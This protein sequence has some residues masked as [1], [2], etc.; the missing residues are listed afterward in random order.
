[1]GDEIDSLDHINSINTIAGANNPP[2]NREAL[3][4][5]S[6]RLFPNSSDNHAA[7]FGAVGRISQVVDP[8][9][10]P[11]A[12]QLP[13]PSSTQFGPETSMPD[14]TRSAFNNSNTLYPDSSMTQTS[15]TDMY[16][17]P[18]TNLT[19]TSSTASSLPFSS[20][21]PTTSFSDIA[22]QSGYS[23][24]A[25]SL[26]TNIML[27]TLNEYGPPIAVPHSGSVGSMSSNNQNYYQQRQ[28]PMQPMGPAYLQSSQ[29][30]PPRN[31]PL[32]NAE[33]IE[34]FI[35]STSQLQ[36]NSGGGNNHNNNVNS[37]SSRTSSSNN[38]N[39]NLSDGT[40]SQQSS[41][42]N[43]ARDNNPIY[44]PPHASSPPLDQIGH[45]SSSVT[46]T[47]PHNKIP[48]RVK[49]PPV[50]KFDEMDL[51]TLRK[52]YREYEIQANCNKRARDTIERSLNNMT[53]HSKGKNLELDPVFRQKKDDQRRCEAVGHEI[54][55]NMQ[56]IS[57][58]LF[59]KFGQKITNSSS[60]HHLDQ[61]RRAKMSTA[62]A[63]TSR[64]RNSRGSTSSGGAN[65]YS[66]LLLD[67]KDA[68]TW[69]QICDIH[70][71]SLKEYC[72]H[73]HK[74][75]HTAAS[76]KRPNPWRVSKD[77]IDLRKTYDIYKSICAK[78]EHEFGEN[79]FNMRKLD[80]ALNPTLKDKEKKLKDLAQNRERNK[81]EDSDPLLKIKGYDYL[82]PITGF[83]CSLCDQALC[84]FAQVEQHLKSYGHTYAHAKS[85]AIDKQ[86]EI[87]F[88]I[89]QDRSYKKTNVSTDDEETVESSKNS[90]QDTEVTSKHSSSTSSAVQYKKPTSHIVDDHEAIADKFP[91]KAA[92]GKPATAAHVP[93]STLTKSRKTANT[94]THDDDSMARKAQSRRRPSD[95]L[96]EIVPINDRSRTKPSAL[97]RLR[98]VEESGSRP[99]SRAEEANLV[100]TDSDSTPEPIQ[101]PIEEAHLASGDPDSPFPELY[102][103][104]T[105]NTH[106]SALRDKRLAQ[107]CRVVMNKINLDDYKDMLL[108]SATLYVRVNQL[109]AKK[110]PTK[111]AEELKKKAVTAPT[112]FDS[113]GNPIP[114]D[115]DEEVKE[116]KPKISRLLAKPDDT[117]KE[118]SESRRRNSDD[119][120]PSKSADSESGDKN[121]VTFDSEPDRDEVRF[122][123]TLLENFFCEK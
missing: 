85:V 54:R 73:L 38:N 19:S 92:V 67:L 120:Q 115:P 98:T 123:M 48:K 70:F 68:K 71:N 89:K 105:G 4:E 80:L 59:I 60:S 46:T 27:N 122:D 56:K 93:H 95:D 96:P 69:C 29:G 87:T 2:R 55:K 13:T 1:M 108:D 22:K 30:L 14:Q 119:L 114:V 42:I 53:R 51:L 24:G 33:Y 23:G 44:S 66:G 57:D 10:R 25:V 110:E 72:D 62:S 18:I 36:V 58:T 21:V 86:N 65:R 76:K 94:K 37:S 34:Q 104:V 43:S 77:P 41:N 118:I 74:R 5:P 100:S 7:S 28:Y 82:I 52:K 88:R 6:Y 63:E 113:D 109:I 91:K 84:D 26:S 40:K 99:T 16:G 116:E 17:R 103:A 31:M 97:K 9:F 15:N 8:Q 35:P 112:F 32:P 49:T 121:M 20:P 111:L 50:E 83:Y 78:L 102:L 117:K 47:Q 39:N 75:E 79:E 45:S 64:D 61:P 3:E 107:N 11:P 106:V 12:P 81:F 90:K 101:K